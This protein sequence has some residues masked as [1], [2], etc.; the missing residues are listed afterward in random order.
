MLWENFEEEMKGIEQ[1]FVFAVYLKPEISLTYSWWQS[2][3]M[4]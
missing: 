3:G 1:Y 2:A 4:A